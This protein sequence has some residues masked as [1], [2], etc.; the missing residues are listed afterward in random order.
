[1]S[2]QAR[3]RGSGSGHRQRAWPKL[4][5]VLHIP[6]HWIIGAVTGLGPSQDSPGFAPALRQATALITLSTVLA[7]AG[8]DAEHNHRLCCDELGIGRSII[9]LNR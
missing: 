3:R 1:V 6:S 8:Y 9:A 4:T 7:D 2:T 5:A